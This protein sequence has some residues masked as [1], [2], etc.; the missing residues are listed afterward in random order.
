MSNDGM[1][2][3][4]PVS[5]PPAV[6]AVINELQSY[7][8]I[9]DGGI[10]VVDIVDATIAIR[11][12]GACVGCPVSAMTQKAIVERML[13]QRLDGISSVVFVE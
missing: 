5:V 3:Q 2:K 10:E 13:A 12:T 9:D 4:V 11:M 1:Q 6:Q 7:L 8:K